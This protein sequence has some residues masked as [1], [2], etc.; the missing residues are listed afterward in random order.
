MTK[1]TPN[2]S[3]SNEEKRMFNKHFDSGRAGVRSGKVTAAQEAAKK[4]KESNAKAVTKLAKSGK[5]PVAVVSKV[6]SGKV[7]AAQEAV[8]DAKLAKATPPRTGAGSGGGRSLYSR[9]TGGLMKHG[10]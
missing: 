7:T 3:F 9:L 6:R 5:V 2:S 4:L 8:R 1:N 10:R